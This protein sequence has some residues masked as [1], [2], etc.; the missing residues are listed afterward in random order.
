MFTR[1]HYW[2]P[3]WS[4][5]IQST[6]SHLISLRPVLM[7]SHVSWE[8]ELWSQ[9]RRLLH[10]NG[11]MNTTVA[12]QWLSGSHMTMTALTHNRGT[13]HLMRYNIIFS[14]LPWS[15]TWKTSLPLRFSNKN[16]IHISPCSLPSYTPCPSQFSL[17]V[18]LLYYLVAGIDQSI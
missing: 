16:C 12:R 7:L 9:Q 15:F 2:S 17:I 3:F 1:T 4:R 8:P 10:G 14:S 5:W 18:S 13:C 11:S 6:P